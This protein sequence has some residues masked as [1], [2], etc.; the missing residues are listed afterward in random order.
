MDY[1]K[2]LKKLAEDDLTTIETE[3]VLDVARLTDDKNINVTDEEFNLLCNII[4]ACW[5][6]TSKRN[7]KTLVA[8]IVEAVVDLYLNGGYYHYIGNH[9]YLDYEELQNPNDYVINKI[10]AYARGEWREDKFLH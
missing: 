9:P 10:L 2:I 7:Y 8:L 4:H 5:N 6:K 3:I 1:S